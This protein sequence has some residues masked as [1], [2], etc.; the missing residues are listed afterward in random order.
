MALLQAATTD[1]CIEILDSAQLRVPVLDRLLEAIQKHLE[2]RVCGK[3]RIGAVLF[4]NQTGPLG[5]TETA[6]KLLQ[7]W[8]ES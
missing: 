1:A 8:K 4:S 7:K 2:H 3:Y 6:E 5:Q